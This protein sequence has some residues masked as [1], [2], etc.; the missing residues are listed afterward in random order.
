MKRLFRVYICRHLPCCAGSRDIMAYQLKSKLCSCSCYIQC[1]AKLMAYANRHICLITHSHHV[2]LCSSFDCALIDLPDIY[3]LWC[4]P[5]K[6]SKT[7]DNYNSHFSEY[8]LIPDFTVEQIN[9]SYYII[10]YIISRY[11]VLLIICSIIIQVYS[12]EL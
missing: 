5:A 8:V 10:C 11:Y 6:S 4:T 2:R 1:V 9:P 12:S 3:R 7:D